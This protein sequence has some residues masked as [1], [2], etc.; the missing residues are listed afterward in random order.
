MSYTGK[1]ILATTENL[2]SCLL[3]F[4]LQTVIPG[5]FSAFPSAGIV[6]K[7]QLFTGSRQ[8][9]TY[10]YKVAPGR[11]LS[12]DSKTLQELWGHLATGKVKCNEKKKKEK[13][14]SLK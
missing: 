1:Q 7:E 2:P 9:T 6:S 11:C 10:K 14:K 5:N 8:T 3:C 13:D 4:L 12:L